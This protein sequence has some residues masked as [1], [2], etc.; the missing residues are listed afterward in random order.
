MTSPQSFR[1]LGSAFVLEIALTWLLYLNLIPPLA[2][3]GR[4]LHGL[5]LLLMVLV[6]LCQAY[7]FHGLQGAISRSL[8][9][10]AF[11]LGLVLGL[12]GVGETLFRL[13]PVYD[14]FDYNPG[15][16]FFWPDWVYF[17]LNNFGHRDRDFHRAKPEGTFRILVAGDSFT[18]GAGVS[19][20]QT[21]CRVL[22]SELNAK[23]KTPGRKIEVYNLG[24]CGMN[25]VEETSLL[26]AQAP[27]L[28]PDMII[29]A[30][31]FND[32]E[33]TASPTALPPIRDGAAWRPWPGL[34]LAQAS[35]TVSDA[36]AAPGAVHHKEWPQTVMHFAITRL[37]SYLAY[38]IYKYGTFSSN[39]QGLANYI[40]SLHND[41]NPGW[42]QAKEAMRELADYGKSRNVEVVGLVF[43]VFIDSPYPQ[44]ISQALAK[45]RDS[46]LQ[47][48]FDQA[49]DLAPFFPGADLGEY[50]LSRFD[51][52]PNAKAHALVGQNLAEVLSASG[53]LKGFMTGAP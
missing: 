49:V 11:S 45:A 28:N 6:L 34:A 33:I 26:L 24:H 16:K 29:L 44:P 7:F 27:L 18:E 43:P 41:S 19:R 37:H 32:P 9:L 21:F 15:V 38:F 23:L 14:S 4:L 31:T 13:Y 10:A 46:M 20:G 12:I 25:T 47:A 36:A 53:K 40:E 39:P 48:G 17:P 1:G 8:G 35:T 3:C 22:E 51:S 52:H 50:A 42:P 2:A 30:Y 5:W